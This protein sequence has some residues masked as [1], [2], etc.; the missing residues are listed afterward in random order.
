MAPR[1]QAKLVRVLRGRIVDM[2]VDLGAASPTGGRHVAVELAAG[3]GRML[4]VPV[5]FA[6][7]FCTLEDDTEIA[8]KCSDLDAPDCDRGLGEY[9]HVFAA[10]EIFVCHFDGFVEKRIKFMPQCTD[11]RIFHPGADRQGGGRGTDLV[12]VGNLR[13]VR[14]PVV[15]GAV[16]SG[17]PLRVYGRCWKGVV[18]DAAL[19]DGAV[20]NETVGNL[21]CGAGVVLNDHWEDMRR[22][23]FVSNRLFDAV[24]CGAPVVSDAIEGR[25]ALTGGII[26]SFTTEAEL[27]ALLEAT[28]HDTPAPA[29]LHRAARFDT[30]VREA[31]AA[32][33]RL[34]PKRAG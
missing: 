29:A 33:A 12:F 3:D 25:E 2:A 26:R 16:A 22:W 31:D 11:P 20:P 18:P 17:L 7:G 34:A 32:R 4:Y 28:L 5:G 19:L 1:A 9:D 14:R 24:A 13:R 27:P 6:H 30:V 10:G 15:V 8:Y 21:Y 23:G